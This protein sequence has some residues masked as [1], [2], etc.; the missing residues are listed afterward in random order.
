MDYEWEPI[1][2]KALARAIE[3]GTITGAEPIDYPLTDGL[4][5]YLTDRSGRQLALD[6]GADP[7]SDEPFYMQ[8]GENDMTENAMRNKQAR[9]E[10]ARFRAAEREAQLTALRR[11]RDDPKTEP[12]DRLRAIEL[13][14]KLSGYNS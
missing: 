10:R 5:I 12:G 7:M 14:M 9:E 3:G 2:A 11:V 13:I 8:I 4:I 6:I 1:G